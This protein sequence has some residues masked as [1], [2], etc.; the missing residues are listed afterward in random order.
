[1]QDTTITTNHS[2]LILVGTKTI[3][4]ETLTWYKTRK[5]IIHGGGH[6][7]I[8]SGQAIVNI[9]SISE[10]Q[11]NY[12]TF[13]I[14]NCPKSVTFLTDSGADISLCKE[15]TLNWY[16]E[17]RTDRCKLMGITKEKI[18]SLGSTINNIK[19]EDD[20]LQHKFQIIARDT[21]IATDG[22]L[23]RDFFQQFHCNIDY[24]PYTLNISPANNNYSLP[25]IENTK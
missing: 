6:P 11:K 20:P 17:D 25:I 5:R 1:M 16:A 22:I 2:T 10:Q 18:H 19:L 4:G 8:N 24:C 13:T 7:R 23:G 15:D 21:P 12:V 14:G 3:T 9:Q